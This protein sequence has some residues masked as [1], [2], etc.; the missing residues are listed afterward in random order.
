[1]RLQSLKSLRITTGS[2]LRASHCRID[3]CELTFEA[4]M[5]RIPNQIELVSLAEIVRRH[6]AM[7]RAAIL[8]PMGERCMFF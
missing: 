1:M 8:A 4:I 2:G 6:L 3:F 5:H 7:K